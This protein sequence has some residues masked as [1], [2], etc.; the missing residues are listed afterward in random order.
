MEL[1]NT[2]NGATLVLYSNQLL[3]ISR[4]FYTVR[5]GFAQI[6]LFGDMVSGNWKAVCF[7]RWRKRKDIKFP[8]FRLFVSVYP[9]V[10]TGNLAGVCY[11]GCIGRTRSSILD[12]IPP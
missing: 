11:F 2:I 12:V 9:H 5:T 8:P 6:F 1:V 7:K 10:G 4:N 3:L